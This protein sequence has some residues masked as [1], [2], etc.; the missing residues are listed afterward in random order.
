MRVRREQETLVR[1]S[2]DR[3]CLCRLEFASHWL[4]K[5]CYAT[6]REQLSLRRAQ[7]N[8]IHRK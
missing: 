4:A 2:R 5:L 6:A 7:A 8:Y 1:R 3:L